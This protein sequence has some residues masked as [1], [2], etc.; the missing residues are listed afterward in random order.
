MLR[1]IVSTIILSI[2]LFFIQVWTGIMASPEKVLGDFIQIQTIVPSILLAIGAIYLSHYF[3][4]EGN[5]K[6]ENL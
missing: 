3:L 1:N 5:V 4:N 2:C 6:K